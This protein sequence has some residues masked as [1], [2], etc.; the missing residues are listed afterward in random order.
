MLRWLV[1]NLDTPEL[2][3]KHEKWLLDHLKREDSK[4]TPYF[5]APNFRAFYFLQEL[6]HSPVLS[7]VRVLDPSKSTTF[8][9]LE[10]RPLS[11]LAHIS[12]STTA[13]TL[14]MP[15]S[16]ARDVPAAT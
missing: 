3:S 1:H 6:K 13:C 4:S 7:S 11:S 9:A 8:S 10:V 5:K 15:A 2:V 14:K 12:V 16:G